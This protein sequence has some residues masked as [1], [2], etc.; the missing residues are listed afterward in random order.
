M[1]IDVNPMIRPIWLIE[2]GVYRDEANALLDEIRRQGMTAVVVPHSALKA[3]N[4]PLLESHGLLPDSCVI[5]YGTFP[6]ARQIQLHSRWSPGAWC[7]PARL[8][9]S[10]YFAYFGKYLLNQHY[11]L[12]P[13]VEAIRQGDWLFSVLGCDDEVFVRPSGCHKLFVGRRVHRESFA[14]ALSP[15]RYD[16]TTLVVIATPRE[17]DREWRLVVLTNRV[18]A[19]SQYAEGGT[20][21][22]APGCPDEVRDF[23]AGM[24]RESP[25]RPDPIFMIDV[26]ETDGRLWVVEFNGFS[27]SW[28]YQCDL[29]IVVERASELAAGQ[30]A[31]IRR[32]GDSR[33]VAAAFRIDS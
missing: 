16:P 13:G 7:D 29:S 17:I 23:V 1:S 31:S 26:C 33:S 4:R 15:T 32:P 28:L 2:A 3:E 24:L 14:A 19:A 21:S 22:V 12:M 5:G 10:A 8:D 18:I 25:W 9:C 27:C 30:W 6:F 11:A 20:R